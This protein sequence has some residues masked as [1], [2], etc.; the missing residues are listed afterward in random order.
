MVSEI[1]YLPYMQIND[2]AGNRKMKNNAQAANPLNT[3][4]PSSPSM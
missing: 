2:N 3:K 4:I 1:S